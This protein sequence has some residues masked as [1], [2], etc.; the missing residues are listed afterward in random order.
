MSETPDAILVE[1]GEADR[2]G[3]SG[4]AARRIAVLGCS[5]SGKST[6]AATLAAKLGLPYVATDQMFWTD[7]WRPTHPTEVRASIREVVAHDRWVTDGNFVGDRDLLWARAELIVWID[8]PLAIV[9][10]QVLQRNLW[11][12]WRR[13]PVWGGQKMTLASAFG[14][15]RHVLRSHNL[16][17]ST[18]PALLAVYEPTPVVRLRTRAELAT[19]A[20]A[21]N[22]DGQGRQ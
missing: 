15:V 20:Q 13:T 17:H 11:W 6:L 7:D 21:L 5:G 2:G 3:V 12:W 1:T 9:L 16:K 14:G 19:W 4:L 8:L 18:Y 22:P 10:A